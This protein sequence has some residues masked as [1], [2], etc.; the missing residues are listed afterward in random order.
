M[1]TPKK[2]INVLLFLVVAANGFSQIKNEKQKVYTVEIIK[3]KFV[4]A[5]LIVEKGDKVVWINKDFLPHDVTDAVKHSWSSKP[6]KQGA[7]WSKIITKDEF[8]F[9]NL[10]K[11]MKGSINV[12]R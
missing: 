11:V 5:D 8:Y 1:K 2:W 7:S 3:M 4:P 10:H 9:C 12:K 6:L